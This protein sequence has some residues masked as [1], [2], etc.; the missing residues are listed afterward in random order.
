MNFTDQTPQIP[1]LGDD[2]IPDAAKS[3]KQRIRSPSEL[4]RLVNRVEAKQKKHRP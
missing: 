2:I 1:N 3:R 4:T